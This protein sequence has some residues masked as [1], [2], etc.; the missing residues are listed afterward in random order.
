E[1]WQAYPPGK[2]RVGQGHG[3]TPGTSG[4][5]TILY[6]SFR[7]GD[8]RPSGGEEPPPTAGDR[9][10]G[11]RSFRQPRPVTIQRGNPPAGFPRTGGSAYPGQIGAY[12][13]TG[14]SGRLFLHPTGL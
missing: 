3:R 2:N 5:C 12:N 6:T 11:R 8:P 1:T 13:C 7:P 9:P 14:W 4:R 10:A